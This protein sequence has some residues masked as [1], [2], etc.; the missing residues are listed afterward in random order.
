MEPLPYCVS[1]A[2]DCVSVKANS[3]IACLSSSGVQSAM[4]YEKLQI[5]DSGAVPGELKTGKFKYIDIMA[6]RFNS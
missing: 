4:Q 2:S 1:F 5:A 6:A 3:L